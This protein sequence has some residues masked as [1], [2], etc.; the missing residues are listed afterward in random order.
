[1]CFIKSIFSLVNNFDKDLILKNILNDFNLCLLN[2]T[3]REMVLQVNPIEI[4]NKIKVQ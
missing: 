2:N 4:N 3:I 1:M